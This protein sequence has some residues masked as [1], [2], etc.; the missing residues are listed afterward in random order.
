MSHGTMLKNVYAIRLHRSNAPDVLADAE[1]T[2]Q[3]C[4]E[5]LL[6][7]AAMSPMTIEEG[8][9]T[10]TWAEY[11]RREVGDVMDEMEDAVLE[12]FMA[13]HIVE[14]PDDCVDE[15]DVENATA[16]GGDG[17]SLP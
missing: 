4:R 13:R 5:R 11:V 10:W 9:E 12:R 6:V 14:Q 8:D 15:C 7:L 16:H 17:R 2:L 3:R 1:E